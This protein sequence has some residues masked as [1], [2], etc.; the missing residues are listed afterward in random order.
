MIGRPKERGL[1]LVV[2]LWGVAALALIAAAMLSTSLSTA[3]IGHNA[4]AQLQVQ[5]AA[6]S[7]IQSAIL[8]LFDTKP[9][10]AQLLDG[11]ARTLSFADIAVTVS[12]QDE[13]GR[14][15]LNYANHDLLRNFFKTVGADDPD[16]IADRVIDWRSSAPTHSTN[17]ATTDDYRNAGYSYRPRGGPFQSVDELGLVMGVTPDLLRR[18]EPGLTVYSHIPSFDT[19]FAT[20]DV[21]QTIP[22]MDEQAA[23]QIARARRPSTAAEGHAYS[24][25]S[26]ATRG[27]MQFSRRAVVLIAGNPR[28]PYWILDWR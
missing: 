10:A 11:R 13:T 20:P 21:L 26:T 4:W 3:K 6:D 9:Q 12:V 18:A 15:D 17:G 14:I 8:S 25:V 1:A 28:Q 2:T 7:G 27:R 22:G 19:R 5:T 24:I 23:D 16:T